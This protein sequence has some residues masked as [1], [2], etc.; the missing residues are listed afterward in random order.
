MDEWSCDAPRV[1]ADDRLPSAGAPLPGICDACGAADGFHPLQHPS[2]GREGLH[3]KACGCMARQ[4]A[5]AR[6]LAGLLDETSLPSV[7]LTEQASPLYVALRRRFPATIGSEYVSRRWRRLRL[8]LWLWRH[9]VFQRIRRG[10]VTRL[11]YA[12]AS[13]DAVSSLD[14]LEHV[15]DADAAFRELAR[16]IRPGGSLVATVPF[17]QDAPLS[18]RIASL[19]LGGN[20]VF[21]GTPEY[22]GDPLGGGVVCFHHFGW[23]LPTLLTNAGFSAAHLRY[24]R[25]PERGLPHGIWVLHARR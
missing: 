5:V 10:D 24:V 1:L 7:Y 20:V 3:C 14:V 25:D 11:G 17:Y 13:L 19:D 23:D 16:V 6:V 21:H 4:R 15:P 12:D 9:G 18:T 2:D 8:M 22:H